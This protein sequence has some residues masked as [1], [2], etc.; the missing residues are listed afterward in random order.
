MKDGA[1]AVP[2]NDESAL[3]RAVVA[4]AT[5]LASDRIHHEPPPPLPIPRQSQADERAALDETLHGPIQLEDRLEG[6]DEPAFLRPGLSRQLLK[7]LRRGRWVVQAQIDL[8]GLGRDAARTA[9][10]EFLGERLRKGQRCIRVI[11]GKGLGSPNRM[12]ILRQLVRGWLMRRTEVLAFCQAQPHD[13]G[14]GALY[15]LLQAPR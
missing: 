4:D 1:S 10:G 14:D 13:G 11:H 7:D 8:H 9:L 15:V 3:F 5:P 12:G 6:G 2:A